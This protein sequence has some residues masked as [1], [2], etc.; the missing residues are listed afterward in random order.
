MTVLDFISETFSNTFS[1]FRM[2]I[3]YS[4]LLIFIV[5]LLVAFFVFNSKLKEFINN[6]TNYFINLGRSLGQAINLTADE[7]TFFS[8]NTIDITNGTI[9]SIGNMLNAKPNM[10]PVPSNSSSTIH[11]TPSSDKA[12]SSIQNPI[13]ATKSSWCLVGQDGS[14]RGCIE[15]K[16]NDKC[17]SGQIFPTQQLC[18]HPTLKQN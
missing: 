8:K 11:V 18:L 4:F 2:N 5:L 1:D 15:V 6:V 9:H 3:V 14:N 7:L 16:D 12:T 13:S 17:L 10:D